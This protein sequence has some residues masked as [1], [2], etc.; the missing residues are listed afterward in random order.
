MLE[1]EGCAASEVDNPQP[2]HVK[3]RTGRSKRA[4]RT[5]R[6][7]GVAAP[8]EL[9]GVPAN[10]AK[11]SR[12][13]ALA[14]EDGGCSD[15]PHI[16]TDS[17]DGDEGAAP[18]WTNSPELRQLLRKQRK[19][20]PASVFGLCPGISAASR[21]IGPPVVKPPRKGGNSN[22][23]V[24]PHKLPTPSSSA[25]SVKFDDPLPNTG[26]ELDD[27]EESSA[28]PSPVDA[29]LTT[30]TPY[31][32]CGTKRRRGTRG[33]SDDSRPKRHQGEYN[34]AKS[35]QFVTAYFQGLTKQ[36]LQESRAA[37][38]ANDAGVR[39]LTNVWCSYA[40]YDHR[41]GKGNATVIR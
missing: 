1:D 16:P 40:N 6:E 36:H 33:R 23:S 22:G 24:P 17:E 12:S 26:R 34:Q 19:T 10:G 21:K 27:I 7:D 11:S 39:C 32:G 5:P 3:P 28:P 15:L 35:E 31:P 13:K 14:Y 4:Q 9:A 18:D 2:L 8:A 37:D 30:P 41:S 38:N 29:V 25:N 20:N